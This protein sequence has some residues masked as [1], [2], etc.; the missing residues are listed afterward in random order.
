MPFAPPRGFFANLL[1]LVVPPII[2][3][4]MLLVV[5]AMVRAN[6]EP[7]RQFL[8][9]SGYALWSEAFAVAEVNGNSWN[10]PSSRWPSR[11]PVWPSPSPSA[12]SWASSCSAP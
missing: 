6:L 1:M 8:M 11:W 3:F 4:G 2:L 12:S 9:P 10:A 7:H 5:Y